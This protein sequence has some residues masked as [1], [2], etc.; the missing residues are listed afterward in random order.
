MNTGGTG[1]GPSNRAYGSANSCDVTGCL[2]TMTLGEVMELQAQGRLSPVV[3]NLFR[4]QETAQQMGLNGR[5][6]DAATQ[7]ALAIGRLHWRLG[8]QNSSLV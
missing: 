8:V 4:P 7:D 1:I 5:S 3:I 2:S 6:L